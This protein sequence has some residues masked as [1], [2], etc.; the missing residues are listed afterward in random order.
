MSVILQLIGLAN[1]AVSDFD[2]EYV[3]GLDPDFMNGLGKVDSTP[4]ITDAKIFPDLVS[5]MAFW[6]TT[7]TVRPIREDGKPNRPLTAFTV[8]PITIS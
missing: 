5:A 2:G 1:G 3:C 8:H 6:K 4:E 7:S